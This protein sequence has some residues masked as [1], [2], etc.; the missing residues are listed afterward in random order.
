M[1]PGQV[2]L[3]VPQ[4][5]AVLSP[6]RKK[7]LEWGRGTG[8]STV[9]GY[10][11][12]EVVTRMPRGKFFLT[13]SSYRQM[14]GTTL[15]STIEGM[16][17]FGL[18][19][20]VHYFVGHRAARKL[21]WPEPFQ[22]PNEWT[23][24]IHFYT[25]AVV[26]LVSQDKNSI[27]NRGQNW[28]GGFGD[29]AA[30]LDEERYFNECIAGNRTLRPAFEQEPLFHCEILASSTPRT[31]E[32]LWFL[33]GEELART[34]PENHV[35]IRADARH[36]AHN[37]RPGWFQ[38]MRQSMPSLADYKAEVLNIRPR[39]T[40][41]AYYPAL[42]RGHYY[43]NMDGNYYLHRFADGRPLD[44]SSAADL[45]V[46][47][48]K[49][50]I[51]SFD[52]GARIN[53]CVVMQKL[54]RQLRTVNEFWKLNP[55]IIQDMIE[56]DI[57]PYYRTHKHK[58]VELF[59]DR[60]ANNRTPDSRRTLAEKMRELFMKAGWQVVMRSLGARPI[61]QDEKYHLINMALEEKDQRLPQLRI[62]KDNCRSLI[63]S[64]E[65]AEAREN[66]K[67]R[68]EKDKRSEARSGP[69]QHAT[70]LAD[71]WDLPVFF[72]CKAGVNEYVGSVPDVKLVG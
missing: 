33:K 55:S 27:S 57:L 34:D 63:V 53:V 37:L 18:R 45:D 10:F 67:G 8:K 32:G 61:T 6:Q 54:G 38:D 66:S 50:L 41:D 64:L 23:A 7:W 72:Y 13:G 36:N 4:M 1:N 48:N 26:Q 62:N 17:L 39:L 52:P 9:F 31:R 16:E 56:H 58:V 49:P 65:M 3:N 46:D 14:L 35:F 70:H 5:L 59:Y 28:D 20:D 30:L 15:P 51:M 47:P 71:A 43:G 44:G 42:S 12:K 60:T 21:G 40:T 29:E 25:G 68:I 11:M 69:Q 19:K 2:Y 24:A 22:P